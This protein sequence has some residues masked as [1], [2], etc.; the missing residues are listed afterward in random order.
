MEEQMSIDIKTFIRDVMGV[1]DPKR[2][3]FFE[4]C[5]DDVVKMIDKTLQTFPTELNWKEFFELHKK[6]IEEYRRMFNE[7][8]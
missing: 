8:T 4:D 6:I 1:P 2:Q 3:P 7:S 5:D